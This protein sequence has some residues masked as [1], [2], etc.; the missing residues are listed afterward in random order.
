MTTRTR[1]EISYDQFVQ[2]RRRRWPWLVLGVI[3]L[4]AAGAA[5]TLLHSS[6]IQAR[7][8]PPP[9]LSA[10]G[11][12][13]ANEAYQWSH[14][15][16]GGGGFI[17]GLSFD[18][19]GNTMVART[20]LYGAY[21]WSPQSNRW[22]QLMT[23][24]TMPEGDRVQG[25]QASGVYEIA[26]APSNPARIFMAARGHVYR[27]DD[28]GAH[29]VASTA[30]FPEVWG[31]NSPFRTNGPFLKLSP[32][33]ADLVFLGTSG[34]LWRS[35]NAGGSWQRVPSV[36]ASVDRDSAAPGIQA[37]GTQIWFETAEGGKPS[38][39]IFAMA[40]GHG[41]LVSEDNGASF[42]ALPSAGAQPMT[43]RRGVF[44]RHGAFLGVDDVGKGVWLYRE[45]RWHNLTQEAGGLS[46]LLWAAAAANPRAD[47][48]VIFDQSGQGFQSTDGGKSWSHVSHAASVGA[49]DP[50]WLKVSDSAYFST[51][52][53]QFDPK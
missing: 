35:T 28:S 2:R 47:Q 43:L 44:D 36:P 42:H 22:V 1:R 48:L 37:P 41:V 29:W 13:V 31:A 9:A 5:G 33:N 12:P 53:V 8:A 38:G 15:A 3:G 30:S 10:A 11:A 18:A 24:Q 25:T 6:Q 19:A 20:S 4:G 34:G 45:G 23:A 26:V 50:P 46:P 27:S 40:S 39:R 49:G 51:G 21:I 17:T 52:D 32:T 14:V 7:H 16:I